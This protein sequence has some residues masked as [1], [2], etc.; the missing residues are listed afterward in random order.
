MNAETKITKNM[1]AIAIDTSDGSGEAD[2]KR[3]D[4][5]TIFAL[6]MNPEEKTYDYINQEFPTKE[7]ERYAP[8]MDQEIATRKGNP[9][10]EFMANKFYNCDLAHGKSLL[11]FP[12]NEKGEKKAWLVCDTT[13]SLT[14][15][16]FVEGKLT[17]TMSFGG[18]IDRGTWDIAD[19][20]IKFTSGAAGASVL[21][22]A[23]EKPIATAA[24]AAKS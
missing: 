20:K 1:A 5:S 6:N 17:W 4:K 24:K 8:S 21:N 18:N 15:A 12:E 16:D 23:A 22:A 7:I 13:F 10:Y 19:G 2:F 14:S 9:I 11:C 3:I